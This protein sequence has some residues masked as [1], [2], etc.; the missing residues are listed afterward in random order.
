[1]GLASCR[2]CVQFQHTLAANSVSPLFGGLSVSSHRAN[3][4]FVPPCDVF[5]RG[6]LMYNLPGSHA[7]GT[8]PRQIVCYLLGR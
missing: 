8:I 6:A 3:K 1:M 5:L 7:P 2:P 4:C